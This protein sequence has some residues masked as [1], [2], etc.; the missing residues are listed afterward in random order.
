[1]AKKPVTKS[2]AEYAD[3][4]LL[5]VLS[6]VLYKPEDNQFLDKEDARENLAKLKRELARLKN[7]D[8]PTLLLLKKISHFDDVVFYKDL[9]IYLF[10]EIFTDTEGK[11]NFTGGIGEGTQEEW[12]AIRLSKGKSPMRGGAFRSTFERYLDFLRFELFSEAAL[13]VINNRTVKGK[14][15][16]FKESYEYNMG[17]YAAAIAIMDGDVSDSISLH[18]M[19][20]EELRAVELGASVTGIQW[21]LPSLNKK[22]GGIYEKSLNFVA[23]GTGSYK[24][25]FLIQQA[26]LALAAGQN[27][28]YISAEMDTKEI[29]NLIIK[30]IMASAAMWDDAHAPLLADIKT[31][32]YSSPE[33]DGTLDKLKRRIPN[34]YQS[35]L[36]LITNPQESGWG[37][38]HVVNPNRFKDFEELIVHLEAEN[39]RLVYD[40]ERLIEGRLVCSTY[41]MVMLDY[42]S[43][44]KAPKGF[45]R[46]TEVDR[47][48]YLADMA[49]TRLASEFDR[50]RGIVVVSAH[51]LNREGV[52]RADAKGDKIRSYDMGGSSWIERYADSIVAL[53]KEGGS[54]VL[55]SSVKSRRTGDMEP[56]LVTADHKT[57]RLEEGADVEEILAMTFAVLTPDS[58]N[59]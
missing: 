42:L 5:H 10:G 26:A 3:E 29:T 2:S 20:E 21:P 43:I 6:S 35:M 54:G 4:A 34:S 25:R 14:K 49:K 23:A 56:Y 36:Q 17:E 57:L 28:M 33:K 48:Q 24:T 55:V 52:K 46:K 15:A 47:L 51:Q 45:D 22:L 32:D 53:K 50:G 30:V 31:V 41:E 38:L 12:E 7:L 18:K 16:T 8:R 39:R 9:E 58:L 37:Y 1:M 59:P 19:T 11:I 13:T 44:L 27:V 40:T